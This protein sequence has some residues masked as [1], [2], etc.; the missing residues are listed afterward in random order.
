MSFEGILFVVCCD[1]LEAGARHALGVSL[2]EIPTWCM[3]TN[4]PHVIASVPSDM[5]V[6]G[7]WPMGRRS[8]ARMAWEDRRMTGT[9]RGVDE[10]FLKRLEDWK[11]KRDAREREIAFAHLKAPTEPAMTAEAPTVT[12]TKTQSVGK[13]EQALGGSK[14]R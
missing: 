5:P 2:S 4:D 14:W 6:T 1:D 7:Y 10:D 8:F 11:A 3:V 9:L 12:A 13:T